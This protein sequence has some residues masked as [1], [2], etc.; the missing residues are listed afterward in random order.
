MLAAPE[1]YDYIEFDASGQEFRWM[2]ILSGDA[3]MLDLCVEGEDPHS[4]MA[5]EIYH[6]DY[7]VIQA[8][9]AAD[10]PVAS[11][12]RKGGKFANL[13]CQYRTG[14]KK[15]RVK[16]RVDY[17]LQI[18]IDEATQIWQTYRNTYRSV[19]EY[20]EQQIAKVRRLGYAETLAGRRVQVVGDWNGPLGWSM[21]STSLN[22]PVQG[23]GG[24]QKYLA[25]SVLRP[26]LTKHGIKFSF[27][28]HDGLYFLSPKDKTERARVEM[29]WLL[30][31][32][33]Y[34][35][36]WGFTPPIPLPWDCKIGPTW[37]RLKGVK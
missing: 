15:L 23:T 8:E 33:P 31:N 16:A 10:E 11:A 19:P 29:Q 14:P 28:L 22:Y 37:G 24:D 34:K 13:S 30:D 1:G 32:L 20:W 6:A 9:A 36:A 26:Y 2:A 35:K 18:N 17:D 27:D 21:Q 7:R 12:K 5:A 3:T 25:L 4:F